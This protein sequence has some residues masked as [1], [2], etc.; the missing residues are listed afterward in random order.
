MIR[1]KRQSP[2]A[3][4]PFGRIKSN[5]A[6][7]ILR[8]QQLESDMEQLWMDGPAYVNEEEPRGKTLR[9]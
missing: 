7:A 8:E 9:V 1:P 2:S 3:L 5:N 4:S 6:A